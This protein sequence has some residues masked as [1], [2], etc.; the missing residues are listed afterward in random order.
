[1]SAMEPRIQF[2]KTEDGVSIAFYTMG[3]GTPVIFMPFIPWSHL[4]REWQMPEFRHILE[5]YIESFML[6]RYDHRGSGLS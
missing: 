2:A 6:I 4:E 1:M 5:P 3:E